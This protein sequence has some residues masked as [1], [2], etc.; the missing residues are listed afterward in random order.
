MR[1]SPA[2]KF[3]SDLPLPLG[4]CWRCTR[5]HRD[6]ATCDAF[7]GGIPDAYLLGEAEHRSPVD[8]DHALQFEEDPAMGA[9]WER[10][11]KLRGLQ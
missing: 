4:I 11:L 8:G 1:Y 6:S 2:D 9:I 7:P 10:Y 3:N 5:K